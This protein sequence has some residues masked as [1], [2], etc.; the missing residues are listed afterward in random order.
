[1]S[2]D[3]EAIKKWGAKV[4]IKILQRS[5]IKYAVPVASIII[6]ASWNYMTTARIG[7][8]AASHF[9]KN[10]K[11]RVGQV[12]RNATGRAKRS[13]R[14]ARPKRRQHRAPATQVATAV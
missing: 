5:I 14:S 9:P 11:E 7:G 1:L 6:G 10:H 13:A 4:G 12:S 8:I 2:V 3:V